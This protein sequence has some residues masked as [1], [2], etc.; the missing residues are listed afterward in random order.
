MSDVFTRLRIAREHSGMS[1]TEMAEHLNM[2]FPGYRD[3]ENGKRTPKSS[4]IEGF[5]KLGYDAN[6]ILTGEGQM[7]LSSQPSLESAPETDEE[8]E[9]SDFVLIPGYSVQV[10]AGAGTFPYDEQP[11]R[12]LAF[13]KKWL[14]FRGLCE[15]DLVLVFARGDSMEPTINDNDTLMI[16]TSKRD[17]SDGSIYVIRTDHHLI[18]KRVQTLLNQTIVLISDNKS[19]QS[20][21]VKLDEAKD[22]EVIG[23]VVWLGKDL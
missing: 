23:K 9:F 2:S 13:R 10:A 14:K 7:L 12:K 1:I 18:V 19:Y 5:I 16:D 8:S 22:L 21:N 17:L 3:N 11:S 6:W 20:I 4:V 15:K